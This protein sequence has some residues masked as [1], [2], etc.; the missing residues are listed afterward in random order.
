MLAETTLI[1]QRSRG[2]KRNSFDLRPQIIDL[3]V[4][5]SA[6]G[7]R[8]A[9]QLYLMPGKTGRP[10]EVLLALGLD[11]LAARIHRTQ[12]LLDQGETS[13][14]VPTSELAAS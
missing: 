4:K 8:L 5:E 14:I 9:M 12:I 11:P 7:A 1:R 10:D 6:D 3:Q 13:D 2:R